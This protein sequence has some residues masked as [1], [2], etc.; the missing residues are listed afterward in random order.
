MIKL[1]ALVFGEGVYKLNSFLIKKILQFKGV[2]VGKNFYIRG[3]PR[4][5]L[6]KGEIVL[7]DNVKIM[8]DIELKSRESGKI[9]IGNDVKIDENCRI[10]AANKAVVEIGNDTG[11]GCYTIFNGG[12]DIKIGNHVL[13]SGFCYI[14]S[15]NHGIARGSLMKKQSHT[16]SPISIGNDVWISSHVTI[17]PG[18]VLEDGVLIG[19]KG[20][21]NSTIPAYS[22]AVGIPSKV[23]KERV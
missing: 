15:S 13:I 22:I 5:H 20:L 17:L 8:G 14:Q 7:G 19:A 2:K 11:I 3:I 1:L 10:I 4:L 16:Y 18:A 12:T 9:F 6:E 23:I 21:V